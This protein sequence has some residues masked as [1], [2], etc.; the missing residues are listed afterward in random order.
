MHARVV[1]DENRVRVGIGLHTVKKD[2]EVAVELLGIP[3]A[4]DDV[5]VQ[6][7]A[8]GNRGENGISVGRS[9]TTFPLPRH[10]THLVPRTR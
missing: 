9:Q 10:S 7:S 2:I 6:Y 3:R 5:E 1:H 4:R 8:K